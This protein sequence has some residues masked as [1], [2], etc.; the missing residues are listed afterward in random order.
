MKQLYKVVHFLFYGFLF[1]NLEGKKIIR[2][3]NMLLSEIFCFKIVPYLGFHGV[4]RFYGEMS[5]HR[6]F[7]AQTA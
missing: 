2:H 7:A 5:V 6:I 1:L 3:V 4:M